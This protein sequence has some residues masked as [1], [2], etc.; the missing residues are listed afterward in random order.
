M[1]LQ[2]QIHNEM[3][4]EANKQSKNNNYGKPYGNNNDKNTK[5]E[6]FSFGRS[7]LLDKNNIG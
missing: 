5:S 6:K 4:E 7:P 1:V 3:Q 2:I